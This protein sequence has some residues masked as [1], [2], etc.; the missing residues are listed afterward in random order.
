[1]ELFPSTRF[2]HLVRDGRDVALSALDWV[3]HGPSV[4]Y[5][6]WEDEP[7]AVCA[8]WWGRRVSAGRAAGPTLGP[9]RYREVQYEALVQRPE[10]AIRDLARFLALPFDP[11]M[12]RFHEGR[13]RAIPGLS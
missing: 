11:H 12:L 7:V 5:A 8:L 9:G 10:G 1:G 4:R 2:V 6:L 3:G 13:A